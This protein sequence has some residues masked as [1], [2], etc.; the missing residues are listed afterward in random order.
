MSG[1]ASIITL[2]FLNF[3]GAENNEV[4]P[5]SVVVTAKCPLRATYRVPEV[6]V[7]VEYDENI[8]CFIFLWL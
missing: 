4:E 8:F 6:T 7:L 3:P 5:D 1:A 2:K